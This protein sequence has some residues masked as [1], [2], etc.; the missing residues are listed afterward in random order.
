MGRFFEALQRAEQE[1]KLPQKVERGSRLTG[2]PSTGKL[3]SPAISREETHQEEDDGFHRLDPAEE[4]TKRIPENIDQRLVALLAPTSLEAERY[5]AIC[6]NIE[7]LHKE[8]GLTM[9]AVSSPAIGDGKTTTAINLA[10]TLAQ[11]PDSKVLLIDMDLRHPSV[12]SALGFE[13]LTSGGVVDIIMDQVMVLEERLWEWPASSLAV[14]P[15]GRAIAAPHAILRSPRLGELLVEARC[16]YDYIVVDTPPLEPFPDCQILAQ[17]ID[18][19]ILVVA[20]HKTPRKLV[21]EALTTIDPTKFV[22]VVFNYEDRAAHK[23]YYHEAYEAS[24]GRRE[25]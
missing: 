20:A 16:R 12:A 19:F 4:H 9:V 10:A 15:A 3:A 23:Y 24:R 13:H 17:W 5:R 2:G 1:H 7:Q 6:F 25:R 8:N 22:G 14:L 11:G 21:G 18:G